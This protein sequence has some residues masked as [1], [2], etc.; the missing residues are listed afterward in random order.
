M[1]SDNEEHLIPESS[2]RGRE[3]SPAASAESSIRSSKRS[4]R[5]TERSTE[6]SKLAS[7]IVRRNHDERSIYLSRSGMLDKLLERLFGP[8]GSS[9]TPFNTNPQRVTQQIKKFQTMIP[10]RSNRSNILLTDVKIFY[11]V[12][13]KDRLMQPY[14]KM[15]RYV[16]FKF[17]D[18]IFSLKLTGQKGENH[19]FAS[20]ALPFIFIDGRGRIC[21]LGNLLQ[22]NSSVEFAKFKSATND[23]YEESK[24]CRIDGKNDMLPRYI[25]S[26]IKYGRKEE[27]DNLVQALQ[28][29]N[30]SNTL[31]MLVPNVKS[32]IMLLLKIGIGIDNDNI[33]QIFEDNKELHFPNM[34]TAEINAAIDKGIQL[35]HILHTTART[36]GRGGSRRYSTKRRSLRKSRTVK[37]RK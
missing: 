1:E 4:K 22:S 25:R 3:D 17:E 10:V 33:K 24:N 7:T 6:R 27:Y 23:S 9:R 16:F 32:L 15:Y 37:N 14:K 8:V 12:L 36:S 5:S 13:P 26:S 28:H 18:A 11:D 19:L 34:T 31:Q 35:T 20:E 2:K 21:T 30:N 29:A